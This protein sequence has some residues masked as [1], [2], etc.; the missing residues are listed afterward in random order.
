MANSQVPLGILPAGTANVLAREAGLR[1]RL[2]SAARQLS[3]CR[4]VR[5]PLGRIEMITSDESPG[6]VRHF[7]LMAG[8]GFDAQIIRDLDPA[9]KNRLGKL[10]YFLGGIQRLGRPLDELEVAVNG[11]RQRCSFALVTKVRNYGGDFEIASRVSLRDAEFE[12][13]SFEG[14]NAMPYLRYLVGVVTRQL[15]HTP[16]V[17]FSRSGEVIL[18]PVDGASVYVHA[19]GELI[20]TLPAKISTVPDALTLLLPP[21]ER[22]PIRMMPRE[23]KLVD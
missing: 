6:D 20:G 7:L 13:V 19:D 16:G 9:A 18:H 22:V 14:N 4:P 2:V 5:V 10:A 15:A 11:H 8:A 3:K 21:F 12:V 1:T 17:H 23:G